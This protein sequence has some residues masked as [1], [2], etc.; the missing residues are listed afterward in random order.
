MPFCPQCKYEYLAGIATCADCD[1]PLVERLPPD[2]PSSSAPSQLSPVAKPVTVHTAANTMEA[3]TLKAFLESGGIP[4]LLKISHESSLAPL[5]PLIELQVPAEREEEARLVL[6]EL[7][8]PAAE[9]RA[10]GPSRPT[11]F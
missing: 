2:E 11:N 1:C 6:Q 9:S 10:E 8:Q 4:C 3:T 5:P 7:S